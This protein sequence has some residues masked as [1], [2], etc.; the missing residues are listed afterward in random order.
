MLLRAYSRLDKRVRKI[1]TLVKKW[2]EVAGIK[3]TKTK[4][5]SSYTYVILVIHYFQHLN[6][7]P[8]LTGYGEKKIIQGKEVQ[9]SQIPPEQWTPVQESNTLSELLLGFFEYYATQVDWELFSVNITGP[10]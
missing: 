1:G 5:L 2:A 7:L 4:T 3:D 10:R 9:F 8:Y 6:M